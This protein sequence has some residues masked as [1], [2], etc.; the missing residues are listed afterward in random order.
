MSWGAY[1]NSAN[2]PLYP[3]GAG[4]GVSNTGQTLYGNT[5]VSVFLAN[6]AFSVFAAD[7]HNSGGA[8]QHTGWQLRKS[9]TGP[10]INVALTAGGN[11][12]NSNGYI[13]FSGVGTSGSGLNVKYIMGNTQN[14]L[15]LTSSNAYFNGIVR[16]EVNSY[17]Y[18][19]NA[20]PSIAS[21]TGGLPITNASFTITAGGRAGRVQVETLVAMNNVA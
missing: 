11:G 2:A 6:T 7:D 19:Y 21:F 18:D 15:Q 10:M 16:L 9:G 17:G 20:A 8:V 13:V 12:V 1:N 5:N 4:Y 3:A 14:T